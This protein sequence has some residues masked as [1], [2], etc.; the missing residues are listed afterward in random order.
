[1]G[2]KTEIGRRLCRRQP[3]GKMPQ[4]QKTFDVLVHMS[5]SNSHSFAIELMNRVIHKQSKPDRKHGGFCV[6]FT[7]NDRSQN[8]CRAWKISPVR[9]SANSHE[10][11]RFALNVRDQRA[12]R[13]GF[14]R[15][16]RGWNFDRSRVRLPSAAWRRSL[17]S[18]LV[19]AVSPFALHFSARLTAD[20][21]VR[22][23]I[24]RMT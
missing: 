1:M 7:Q 21:S 10:T 9:V 19:P 20:R 11:A 4:I 17:R 13:C 18:G 5:F 2:G 16:R 22:L 14:T 3:V 24:L 23:I 6:I 15:A 8:Q 12:F